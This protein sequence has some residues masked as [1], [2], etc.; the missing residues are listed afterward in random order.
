[1]TI[2]AP[3]GSGSPILPRPGFFLCTSLVG[4]G[5]G[6]HKKNQPGSFVAGLI[7]LCVY[8]SNTTRCRPR[9]RGVQALRSHPR[10]SGRGIYAG[11]SI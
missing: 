9:A 1:M 2:E 5:G 8:P 6:I 7:R 4:V 10:G 11:L 3:V